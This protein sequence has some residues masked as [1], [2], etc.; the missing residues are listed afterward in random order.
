MVAIV[1]LIAA[2]GFLLLGV[3]MLLL[4]LIGVSVGIQITGFP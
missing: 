4:S 2:V 1:A 3:G